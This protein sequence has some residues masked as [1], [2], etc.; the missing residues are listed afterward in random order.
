MRIVSQ[1]LGTVVYRV[2]SRDTDFKDQLEQEFE[3]NHTETMLEF[4]YKKVQI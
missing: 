4:F 3:Q 1:T 2:V